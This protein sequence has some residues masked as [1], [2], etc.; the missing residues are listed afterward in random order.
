[1]DGVIAQGVKGP[2]I[3]VPN[4]DF[5]SVIRAIEHCTAF[6]ALG[7]DIGSGHM[8]QVQQVIAFCI[9]TAIV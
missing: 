8:R 6:I 2:N 3:E 9:I 4:M 7:H 1:M 5:S